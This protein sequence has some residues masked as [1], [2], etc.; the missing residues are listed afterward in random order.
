MNANFKAQWNSMMDASIA[1]ITWFKIMKSP[2]ACSGDLRRS[3]ER[4]FAEG[5][6]HQWQEGN[7]TLSAG[8]INNKKASSS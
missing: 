7:K 3:R 1:L 6:V 2:T 8:L 4:E 5:I